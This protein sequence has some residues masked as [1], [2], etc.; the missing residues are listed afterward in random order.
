MKTKTKAL[1]V[2][3][4]A[5]LL[6]V[7]SVMGTMAYLTSTET[8]KNTFTVGN[9]SIKL[10]E[11]KVNEDGKPIEGA[12]RVKENSYHLMP[13]HKYTKDPTV[14]VLKGS[15]DSYVRMNVTVKFKNKLNDTTLAT[16]LDEI[17]LGYDANE[18]E[19]KG[20]RV[21]TTETD[22]KDPTK[23]YTQ[24]TYEYRYKETVSAKDGKDVVLPALF[25]GIQIPDSW[26]N[27]NLSAIG[28]FDIDIVAEAIQADGFEDANAA[29]NA[30]KTQ[31][32][33]ETTGN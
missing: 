14:T 13:G 22:E 30:F 20:D 18:W 8:V 5:I 16:K 12:D 31:S 1:A 24:I 25:T 28:E 4:C 21:I 3:L 32:T 19:R 7:A 11:A 27:D 10:D 29:W 9:V 26:T 6:V 23:E 15:D 33:T 17:F 2:S